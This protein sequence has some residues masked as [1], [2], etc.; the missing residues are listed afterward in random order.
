MNNDKILQAYDQL[1]DQYDA[2]YDTPMAHKEDEY[3]FGQLSPWL[4]GTVADIGAGTG[5][6]L[7]MVD[8]HPSMY[9]GIEPSHGM[10]SNFKRKHPEHYL[11]IAT[12]ETAEAW[13]TDTAVSL[14]GS[15][16]YIEPSS[17]GALK[18]AGMWYF[19]MFYK[20]G[21]FPD[22]ENAEENNRTDFEALD[23]LFEGRHDWHNWTIYTNT[24]LRLEAL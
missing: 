7:D 24:G 19:F 18:E 23:L 12:F 3:L 20:P 9:H 11:E 8:V 14:Y 5:L 1:A 22:F 17:Y 4:R 16:S 13:Y 15:P 2:R 10:A 21:Y 6:L